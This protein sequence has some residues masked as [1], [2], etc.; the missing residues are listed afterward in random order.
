MF[1]NPKEFDEHHPTC[2]CC[3]DRFEDRLTDIAIDL[4]AREVSRHVDDPEVV[5]KQ[6]ED[7][8]EF[9]EQELEMALILAS[10]IAGAV[11]A[12]EGTINSAITT[13][14]PTRIN[15]AIDESDAIWRRE[16]WTQ[17][18]QDRT[19]VVIGQ[20]VGI[21]VATA[22][23]AVQLSALNRQQLIRG[24][25]ASANYYT[26]EYFNTQVMPSLFRAVEDAI[27]SGNADSFRR[28]QEV[29]SR[30]LRSVPYWNV[31]ANAA[32]QR[33]FHFGLLKGGQAAGFTRVIYTTIND[34]RRSEICTFLDGTIW[35]LSTAVNFVDK[36]A[37]IDHPEDI[38]D[39]A[40]WPRFEDIDGLSPV[41]LAEAG[42]IV[43]PVHGNCRSTLR[44]F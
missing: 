6:D 42:V 43:P 10:G 11:S 44:L 21:G 5:Q 24:M 33:A 30:R 8:V 36:I 7:D 16:A 32:A 1:F 4:L 17:R 26:N 28:V 14:D 9:L 38:K 13:G 18:T 34:E 35:E 20:T 19:E 12:V 31:V 2:P 39:L 25:V 15:D 41:E 3:G 37:A 29:M 22:N 40:G 27:A 23:D